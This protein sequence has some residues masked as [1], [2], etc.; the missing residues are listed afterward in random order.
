MLLCVGKMISII[1]CALLG[2]PLCPAGVAEPQF[3]WMQS[4]FFGSQ[5]IPLVK[6][7]EPCSMKCVYVGSRLCDELIPWL[8]R[9]LSWHQRISTRICRFKR[10]V[11]VQT[12]RAA[13]MGLIS[14]DAF[15]PSIGERT[16]IWHW[17]SLSSEKSTTNTIEWFIASR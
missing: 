17:T 10:A 16:I 7:L 15:T 1:H 5:L 4:S 3:G 6:F 13:G 12:S 8:M 9:S 11:S 2:E 14:V